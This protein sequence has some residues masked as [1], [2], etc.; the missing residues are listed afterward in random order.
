MRKLLSLALLLLAVTAKSQLLTWSPAFIKEA[1]TP[2]TIFMDANY[3]NKALLNYTPTT[4]V[5]VHIGAITSKS[6]SGADWK[7]VKFTWG[8]TTTAAQCTYLGNNKWR[9]IITGGLRSFFNITDASETVKKIAILFRN[10][11]GSIVERNSDGSD[12]YIPVYDNGVY[13]RI[14]VPYKQPTYVPKPEPIIKNIGDALSITA[15][16]SVAGTLKILFNGTQLGS[17]SATSLTVNTTVTTS[18]AQQII[19]EETSGGTTHR[20]TVNFVV[21]KTNTVADIPEG[22]T[23]GINYETGDTS[24]VLVLYAPQ[25]KNIFVIGDFNNW[26][27]STKYQMNITPDGNRYWIRLTGLTAGTEYAYQYVIDQSLTVADYNCEKILDPYNDPYISA[28][29]Y[30][31]L[32]PYPTGKTSGNVS[33]LQTKKPVYVWQVPNFQ[34]PNKQN[35]VIYEMLVRDFVAAQNF[36]TVKDTLSYLK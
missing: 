36:Q 23:D 28:I 33:V 14:D 21:P 35:I 8:S 3:G 18:D 15:K 26:S 30:P 16:S 22:K 31:N 11:T 7:Y 27:L 24:A 29:T 12:M 2:D 32:K 19:A 20:D 13:A 34:R 5:Y 10:G 9:Y 17:T 1:S 25:K 6:A 4:D